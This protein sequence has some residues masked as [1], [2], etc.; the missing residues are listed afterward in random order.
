[1]ARGL[2]S[3]A[4]RAQGGPSKGA[5]SHDPGA[6]VAAPVGALHGRGDAREQFVEHVVDELRPVRDVLVE[7]HGVTPRRSRDAAHACGLP[8]A[9]FIGEP[10]GCGDDA[11]AIQ[12]SPRRGGLLRMQRAG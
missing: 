6:D 9:G 2:V 5:R 8:E 10:D 1:M 3:I 7:G 4:S 11:A 12:R